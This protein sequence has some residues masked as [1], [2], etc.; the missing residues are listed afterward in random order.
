MLSWM[1]MRRP[2]FGAVAVSAVLAVGACGEALRLEPPVGSSGTSNPAGTGGGGSGGGGPVACVSNSD[3]PAPTS[4]CDTA[5]ETCVECLVFVDCGATPGTVCSEGSCV[6]PV[7]AD[8][9]CE[10]VG[11]VDRQT[12]TEHCGACGHACFGACV[13]GAC[14]DAWEPIAQQGAPEA[15]RQ[16]VSVWTGSHMIVWGGDGNQGHRNDGAM[17]DPVERKWTAMSPVNAPSARID[18]TAVWTG[19]E[20][21]VWG[22]RGNS[23]YL[24]DGAIFT[25]ATNTWKPMVKAGAPA[26]RRYHTSVWANNADAGKSYMVVWGGFD[27]NELNTG[28]RY[29][30]G[31]SANVEEGWKSTELPLGADASRSQHSAVWDGSKMLIYGGFGDSVP[32]MLN[33]QFFPGAA[34]PGGRTYDPDVNMWGTMPTLQEPPARR[35]HTAVWIE[36]EVNMAN[37][38]MLLFG[39]E[40]NNIP[41]ADAGFEF[42]NNSWKVLE[43]P[44]P[45]ARYLHTAVWLKTAGK[46]VVWGGQ[47][48]SA[49]L[50]TGAVYDHVANSWDDMPLATAPDA[51]IQHTAVSSDTA[52]LVWGGISQNNQRLNSGAIYTP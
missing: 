11:C 29:N 32:L 1:H 47:T 44:L 7:A 43:G 22:G 30:L 12:S 24:N 4:V 16:H 17:Y 15:R 25:P 52:M 34:V 41:V 28:G 23:P 45:E 19:K 33:N 42:H 21:I 37:S 2:L 48:Q 5:N 3:C 13:D 50:N 51:R 39:G 6:C 46:M 10:D 14:V 26:A 49:Y 8:S 36:D 40:T 31:E 18:A 9:W 27:G 38:H 20:M 35:Q